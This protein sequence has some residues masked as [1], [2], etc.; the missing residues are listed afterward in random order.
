MPAISSQEERIRNFKTAESELHSYGVSHVSSPINPR[1]SAI[2]AHQAIES[3]RDENASLKTRIEEVSSLCQTQAAEIK[4]I[5]MTMDR[6]RERLDRLKEKGN[7]HKKVNS[8]EDDIDGVW[9]ALN[10]VMR[11]VGMKD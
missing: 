4:R 2:L 5:S 6:L 10:E 1:R 8:L 11:V 3:L 9:A 7:W